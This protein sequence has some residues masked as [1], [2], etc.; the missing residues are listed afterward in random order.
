MTVVI[1]RPRPVQKGDA[2]VVGATF[3][4]VEAVLPTLGKA[5]VVSEDRV[6]SYFLPLDLVTVGVRQLQPFT[7]TDAQLLAWPLC[8][9]CNENRVPPEARM[10]AACERKHYG[11]GPE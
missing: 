10:C 2:L 7:I 11:D 1:P 9:A 5:L 4:A 3:C 6:G 8:P